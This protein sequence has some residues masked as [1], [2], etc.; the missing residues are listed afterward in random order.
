MLCL[1]NHSTAFSDVKCLLLYRVS[2]SLLRFSSI[3]S[4]KQED[5]FKKISGLKKKKKKIR[6]LETWK[7]WDSTWQGEQQWFMMSFKLACNLAAL[8]DQAKAQISPLTWIIVWKR[9]D[10]YSYT[11]LIYLT[12]RVSVSVMSTKARLKPISILLTFSCF[13]N[14]FEI[15]F[16]CYVVA[17]IR[18]H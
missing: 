14:C 3:L 18:F 16:L 9:M 11:H 1:T 2:P 17:L 12:P 10:I 5:A 13:K 7:I 4:V 8:L 6:G 15:A